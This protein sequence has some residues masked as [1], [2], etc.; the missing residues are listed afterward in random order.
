MVYT[1]NFL[2]LRDKKTERGS[3][4]VKQD[5]PFALAIITILS[6]DLIERKRETHLH[7]TK[8][9]QEL[10]SEVFSIPQD[11]CPNTTPSSPLRIFD[12]DP[13]R[14]PI[15]HAD[16]GIY[17]P[18]RNQPDLLFHGATEDSH[19]STLLSSPQHRFFFPGRWRRIEEPTSWVSTID[20]FERRK[21]P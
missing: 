8:K 5:A 20:P 10:R 2:A 3:Q 4:P 6:L 12:D 1:S 21:S 18:C 15:Q 13:I 7:Q 19:I 16:F 11:C 9:Q 14:T 17:S